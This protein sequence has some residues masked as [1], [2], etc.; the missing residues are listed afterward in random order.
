MKSFLDGAEEGAILFSMGFIFNP[1][2]V[3][4]ERVEAF[5]SA[6]RKLPQRVIFKYDL[7]YNLSLKVP[8]N[9]LLVPWVPPQ[10]VLAHHSL[11]IFLTHRGMNGVL[12]AIYYE[13][14]MVGMPDASLH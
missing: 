14:A 4:Q 6:F 3:P 13:V 9:V 7:N 2:I 11:N 10:A 12:E 8:A 1:T 5:L